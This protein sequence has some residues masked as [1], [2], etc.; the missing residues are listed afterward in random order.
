MRGEGIGNGKGAGVSSE[1]PPGLGS[2]DDMKS[3]NPSS[4]PSLSLMGVVKEI[5]FPALVGVAPVTIGES[6]GR[7]FGVAGDIA[8]VKAPSIG[9]PNAESKSSK[10]SLDIF[11]CFG[12]GL[13]GGGEA[14]ATEGRGKTEGRR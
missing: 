11:V 13:G 5:L 4:K 7:E 14:M 9:F 2:S 6:E 1:R 12:G 3:P 10:S 8:G